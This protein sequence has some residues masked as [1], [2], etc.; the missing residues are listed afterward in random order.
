MK[1]WGILSWVRL[2]TGTARTTG[3]KSLKHEPRDPARTGAR[4]VGRNPGQLLTWPAAARE[5]TNPVG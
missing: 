3:T 2:Q 1:S 5:E 4:V